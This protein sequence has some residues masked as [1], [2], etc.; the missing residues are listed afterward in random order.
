MNT[1]KAR[2]LYPL[3]LMTNTV[4]LGS[5]ESD[6]HLPVLSLLLKQHSQPARAV[7]QIL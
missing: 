5:T 7:G 2:V 4:D 3:Y 1:Y 6:L